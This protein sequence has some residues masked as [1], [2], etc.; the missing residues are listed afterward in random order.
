MLMTYLNALTMSSHDWTQ[1]QGIDDKPLHSDCVATFKTIEHY[2]THHQ[3]KV[4]Y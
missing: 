4:S 3:R 1:G 2:S